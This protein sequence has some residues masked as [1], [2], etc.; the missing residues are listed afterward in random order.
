M[1]G[2]QGNRKG[3]ALEELLR[4]YFLRAGFFVVRGVPFVLEGEELTDVDLWLYERPTGTTRRVQIVDVKSK[5]KPK[6]VERLFWTKGL[7]EALG[8]D[9]AYVAT[10]DK[11]EGLRKIASILDLTLIDGTDIQRIRDSSS[12]SFRDRITDEQLIAELSST[13]KDRKTKDLSNL[14]LKVLSTLSRGFGPA[15]VAGALDL[16]KQIASMT[17]SAF[18]G[19]TSA[20]AIGRLTYLA[21]AIACEALDYVSVAAPFRSNDERREL[22][23]NAVRYGAIGHDE[24]QRILRVAVELIRKYAPGGS[25]V[26]RKVE[27]GVKSDLNA[28]PAEIIADQAARMLKDGQL[29]AVGRELERAAYS[30]P[31]P[32]FDELSASGKSFVGALLDYSDINRE[33]FAAAWI[34]QN[35]QKAE[36][37]VDDSD[38][39]QDQGSLFAKTSSSA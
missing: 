23:L 7:S 8:V 30:R 4:A 10:T 36:S 5:S 32:S 14:R 9:G 26:A 28:I 37:S 21:A 17:V 33:S 34:N 16:F 22:I 20:V 3:V 15:T 38:T 24:G 1:T 18:P 13:D 39:E 2:K 12:V 29:F 11:R 31:C 35:A 19:S 25:G 27:A 6:A